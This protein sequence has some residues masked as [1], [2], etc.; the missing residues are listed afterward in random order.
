MTADRVDVVVRAGARVWR[1]DRSYTAGARLCVPLRLAKAWLG[2][3]WVE[4]VD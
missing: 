3:G 1:G 2:F 4:L